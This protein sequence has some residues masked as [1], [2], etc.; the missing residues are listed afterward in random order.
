MHNILYKLKIA[1]E[2]SNIYE[3]DGHGKLKCYLS[4]SLSQPF[5]H[6][7]KEMRKNSLLQNSW[8][9]SHI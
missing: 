7:H 3:M 8:K 2:K 4:K 9:I 1:A 6:V 5:G